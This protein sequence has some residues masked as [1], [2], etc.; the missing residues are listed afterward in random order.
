MK[1]WLGLFTLGL[2]GLATAE[3]VALSND[4]LSAATGGEGI[5]M[6]LEFALNSDATGT[7]RSG[8][9]AQQR[10]FALKIDN[11]WLVVHDVRGGVV[12]DELQVDMESFGGKPAMKVSS[13]GLLHLNKV[14]IGGIFLSP[15]SQNG[16]DAVYGPNPAND[17]RGAYP[18]N[19]QSVLGYYGSADVRING[20][21]YMFSHAVSAASYN[22][23]RFDQ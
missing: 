8:T 1:F 13:P 17:P 3:P 15:D 4:E 20:S 16:G 14:Q 5:S 9:T 18:T 19:H 6:Y 23:Y 11:D 7:P 22:N 10:R 21:L 12:F 2:S